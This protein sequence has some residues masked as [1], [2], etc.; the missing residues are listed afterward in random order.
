MDLRVLT[1]EILLQL[2]KADN[3]KAFKERY[4]PIGNPSSKPLTTD[5]TTAKS[6]KN[7]YKIFSSEFP[8][9]Q[10]TCLIFT[11]IN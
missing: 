9:T 7:W 8:L 6:P 5:S 3:E 11:L 1:D 2:L 10:I 4:T